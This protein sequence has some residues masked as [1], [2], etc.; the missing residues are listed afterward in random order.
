MNL[1]RAQM[2]MVDL[3]PLVIQYVNADQ[4]LIIPEICNSINV[5]IHW[6]T[7]FHT[8]VLEEYTLEHLAPVLHHIAQVFGLVGRSSSARSLALARGYIPMS[9]AGS[10]NQ[11]LPPCFTNSLCHFQSAGQPED[12]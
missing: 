10:F 7:I 5:N 6:T 11:H 2:I 3:A 1:N 9:G 8:K 12:L 4:L